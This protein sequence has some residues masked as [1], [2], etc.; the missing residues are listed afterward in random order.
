M[1]GRCG[2]G[3]R[4]WKSRDRLLVRHLSLRVL[5]DRGGGEVS[6]VNDDPLK[7]QEPAARRQG[8]RRPTKRAPRQPGPAASAPPKSQ[9][10]SAATWAQHEGQEAPRFF[11][12]D[13]PW[14]TPR[15]VRSDQPLDR[16]P[17]P[18]RGCTVAEA[19]VAARG[20]QLPT[21]AGVTF[22]ATCGVAVYFKSHYSGGM[23][24]AR[25][26]AAADMETATKRASRAPAPLDQRSD[27][28]LA[29]LCRRR[30]GEDTHFAALL[31]GPPAPPPPTSDGAPEDCV[32]TMDV[33]RLLEL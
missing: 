11:F 15:R 26:G 17:W 25:T 2:N 23:H 7:T 10:R 31:S 6:A 32:G 19:D 13:A 33:E 24:V 3:G 28:D 16:V 22:C 9:G 4:K 27:A 18:F 1:R 21:P 12:S 20:A 30:M 5:Y 14:K 8:R 29:A